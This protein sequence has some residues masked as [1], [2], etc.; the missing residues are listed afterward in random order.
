MVL[1]PPLILRTE[2]VTVSCGQLR[3]LARTAGFNKHEPRGMNN[4]A[5]V[6][7]AALPRIALSSKTAW[8][9]TVRSFD[10]KMIW[11]LPSL[12]RAAAPTEK[13]E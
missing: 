13:R 2:G 5:R 1:L 7:S 4:S 9:I 10:V 11:I 12:E 3:D 6:Y 8:L